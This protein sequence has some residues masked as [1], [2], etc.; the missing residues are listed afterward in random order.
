MPFSVGETVIVARENSV[1]VPIGSIGIIR[2]FS[3]AGQTHRRNV[4]LPIVDI[5]GRGRVLIDAEALDPYDLPARRAELQ[6][7]KHPHALPRPD[8]VSLADVPTGLSRPRPVSLE[9][10][11]PAPVVDWCDPP[12]PKI[13]VPK[14]VWTP[15]EGGSMA[16]RESAPMASQL[17][18]APDSAPVKRRGWSEERKAKFRATMA[19]KREAK[20][21]TERPSIYAPEVEAAITTVNELEHVKES[22]SRELADVSEPEPARAVVPLRERVR[23]A[24]EHRVEPVALRSVRTV[25]DADRDQ[26]ILSVRVTIAAGATRGLSARSIAELAR[27]LMEL[28]EEAVG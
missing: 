19:A 7:A 16:T 6:T 24:P 1:H 8:R 15:Q 3:A 12:D 28:D 9:P 4:S 2:Q 26:D 14:P 17:D 13:R 20:V 27:L 10:L 21:M 22:L 23:Q 18:S 11:P 25:Q 5:D